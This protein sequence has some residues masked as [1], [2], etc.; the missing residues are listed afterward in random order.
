MSSMSQK[1][2]MRNTHSVLSYDP[3]S[4]ITDQISN[5]TLYSHSTKAEKISWNV[6]GHFSA[7]SP[8]RE[9][10]LPLVSVH[11]LSPSAPTF[12]GSSFVAQLV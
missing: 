11:V 8:Q 7:V 5:A 6:G 4:S 1:G 3:E 10:S 12:P 9:S 2:L